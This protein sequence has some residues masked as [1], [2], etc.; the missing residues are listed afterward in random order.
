MATSAAGWVHQILDLMA[1]CIF[2]QMP[3]EALVDFTGGFPEEYKGPMGQGLEGLNHDLFAEMKR[4]LEERPGVLIA[5]CTLLNNFKSKG[6][7]GGHAY[8]VTGISGGIS[9]GV[10]GSKPHLLRLVKIR[11]PWGNSFE[12]TVSLE[13][14]SRQT[15][16]FLRGSG[17]TR[18]S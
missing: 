7:V 8:T 1:S 11:N 2:L 16:T 12:W 6:I 9:G 14:S 5:A 4:A 15:T 10:S 13:P 18:A 3:V 17:A